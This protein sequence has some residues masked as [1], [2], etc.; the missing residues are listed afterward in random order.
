MREFA[1]ELAN[2]YGVAVDFAIHAPH[3]QGDE[4][5]Y[6]AHVLDHDPAIEAGGLG[7]KA[8]IEWSDTDRRKT[9]LGPAKEEVKAIRAQWAELT[10]EHLHELGIEAR[11]DHRS[12][13]D[14]G[15]EREPT[16][17]SRAGGVGDGTARDRDRGR[18]AHRVADAGGGAAAAR[19]GGRA[20]AARARDA[21]IATSSCSFSM[22]T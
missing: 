12:L 20:R 2:R 5:N 6:H 1:R 3:R 11:I 17:P 9:G 16:T 15:I 4:R 13:E 18:Q 19:A 10:N 14:Q 21:D 8:A 22:G 7:A